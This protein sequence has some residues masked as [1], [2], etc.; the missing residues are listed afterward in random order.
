MSGSN[1][2][3]RKQPAQAGSEVPGT[4]D[5]EI[6]RAVEHLPSLDT[7]KPLLLFRAQELTRNQ[8]L[9]DKLKRQQERQSESC[10]PTHPHQ[11][12]GIMA[13][14]AQAHILTTELDPRKS[15]YQQ[16]SPHLNHLQ[17]LC[18]SIHSMENQGL[19]THQK[20]QAYIRAMPISRSA[21]GWMWKMF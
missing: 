14:T 19:M 13:I 8:N 3:R 2:F 5:N 15:T 12:P 20:K 17:T 16:E 21:K 18:Q 6:T 7:G 1:P 11:T 9:P 10:H 4:S